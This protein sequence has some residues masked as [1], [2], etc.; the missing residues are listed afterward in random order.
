MPSSLGLER[1]EFYLRYLK[2]GLRAGAAYDFFFAL[3]MVAAP[4][5]PEELLGLRP[6]G[7]AYFLWL[8]AVFLTMLGASYLFAAYDPRAYAGIIWIA[9]VGRF[10]GFLVMA[11]AAAN[12]PSLQGLWVLAA[13]DLFFAVVHAVCFLPIRRR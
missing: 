10:L 3:V 9:I 1:Y 5:I 11:W 13:G 12:D 7:D 2:L 4:R 6:P 8:F